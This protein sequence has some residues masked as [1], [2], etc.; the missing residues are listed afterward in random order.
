MYFP[1]IK[2][3]TGEDV[4]AYHHGANKQKIENLRSNL[5]DFNSML[6]NK[7]FDQPHI[8]IS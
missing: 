1:S 6:L 4:C 8:D 2:D 3:D 5:S 7:C